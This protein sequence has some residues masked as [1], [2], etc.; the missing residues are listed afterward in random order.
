MRKYEDG[1]QMFKVERDTGRRSGKDQRGSGDGVTGRETMIAGGADEA[2][3][4]S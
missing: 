4:A 2:S 3:S 1:R